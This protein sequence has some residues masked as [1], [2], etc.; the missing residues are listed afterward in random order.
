[1]E[2]EFCSSDQRVARVSSSYPC[3]SSIMLEY[4]FKSTFFLIHMFHVFFSNELLDLFKKLDVQ[5]FL[6]FFF[7]TKIKSSFDIRRSKQIFFMGM[8][9]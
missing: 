2:V 8:F 5:V 4:Q 7:L 6:S 9:A 1:M 3:G